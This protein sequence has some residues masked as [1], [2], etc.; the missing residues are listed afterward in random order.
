MLGLNSI[1]N[2]D[3]NHCNSL[4]T[5]KTL[6]QSNYKSRFVKFSSMLIKDEKEFELGELV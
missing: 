3:F 5:L 2:R 4:N 1:K 6:A